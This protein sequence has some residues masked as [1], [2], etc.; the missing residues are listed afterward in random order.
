MRAFYKFALLT[1]NKDYR[2][3]LI[4]FDYYSKI[5]WLLVKQLKFHCHEK[6][7]IMFDYLLPDNKNKIITMHLD[8]IKVGNWSTRLYL[9]GI[10]EGMNGFSQLPIDKILMIKKI[11]KKNV[12]FNIETNVLTYKISKEIYEK[13]KL[14]EKEIVSEI[15]DN[16]VTIKR[17]LDDSFYIIQ[18]LLY[19][20]PDL[21]YISD[22]KIKNMVLEKL[23][24][25][26]DMYN[27]QF[28]K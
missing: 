10:I 23:Y 26:K 28:D 14:D 16:I 19:F 8:T 27:G 2:G 24:I 4:N 5:N 18:R 20:C 7:I 15:K 25:L 22:E 11:I 17:P 12:R 21:Y 13:E 1:Q 3:S 9:R 6:D